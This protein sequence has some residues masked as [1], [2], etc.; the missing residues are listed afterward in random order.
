MGAVEDAAAAAARLASPGAYQINELGRALLR[1]IRAQILAAYTAMLRH[2][3]EG[4]IVD[5]NH[6]SGMGEIRGAS[7]A[8]APRA[9]LTQ[10]A[11]TARAKFLTR[12]DSSWQ[13]TASA[14]GR[15]GGTSTP[16][17]T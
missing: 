10:A 1:A 9:H 14:A 12:V 15:L 8:D 3:A 6:A 13:A 7:G 16:P 2:Q 17:P 4:Q 11:G 5:S